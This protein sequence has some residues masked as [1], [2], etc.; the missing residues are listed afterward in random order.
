MART[1]KWEKFKPEVIRLI[2]EGLKFSDIRKE[3]PQIPKG[4]LAGWCKS[5]SEQR[6][7]RSDS[8]RTPPKLNLPIDPE[9][10]IERVRNKLWDIA[11]DPEGKGVAVQALNAIL[12]SFE[13]EAR[14]ASDWSDN[15]IDD[16]AVQSVEVAF[17]DAENP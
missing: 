1:G 7:E 5:Y 11:D 13:V 10:P 2:Q 9:S 6:A 16:D 17:V 3:F 12:K 14:L 15:S 8:V 4:T